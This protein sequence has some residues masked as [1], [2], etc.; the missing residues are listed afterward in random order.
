M[1]MACTSVSVRPLDVSV[2]KGFG[3]SII[4]TL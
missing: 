4:S 2:A 3:K 1:L